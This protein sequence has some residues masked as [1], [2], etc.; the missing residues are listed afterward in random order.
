MSEYLWIGILA[1]I[2][3]IFVYY[4][5]WKKPWQG[6]LEDI[7]RKSFWDEGNDHGNSLYCVSM[8]RHELRHVDMAAQE[9]R[10][11]CGEFMRRS[12]IKEANRVLPPVTNG[13]YVGEKETLPRL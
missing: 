8:E 3:L 5:I 10:L 4:L 9:L 11:Q 13:G 2:A 1:Q 6:E 12:A 7:S